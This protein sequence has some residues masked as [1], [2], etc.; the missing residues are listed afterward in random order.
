MVIYIA[1]SDR[2]ALE[3][4][5]G[6]LASLGDP[7]DSRT[8]TA[9]SIGAM[10]RPTNRSAVRREYNPEFIA[11]NP[12]YEKYAKKL[13]GPSKANNKPDDDIQPLIKR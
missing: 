7:A 8:K 6:S 5:R 11:R 2:S 12:V 4:Q 9:T 1:N 10:A 13:E 3:R